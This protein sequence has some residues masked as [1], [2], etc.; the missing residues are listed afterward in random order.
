V[1]T[2]GLVLGAQAAGLEPGPVRLGVMF[3]LPAVLCYTFVERPRRFAL[4]LGALLL[5]GALYPGV[6]GRALYRERDFFGVHRVTV[7]PT[8]SF[9]QLV[10]GNTVH[11]RQSLDPA[12]RRLPLTYYHPSGPIGQVFGALRGDPRLDRVG[13][14]GLGAGSLACYAEAGQHWTYFEIDPAVVRIA[15]D[16]ALFTF[17]DDCPARLDVVLGDAR[18]TLARGDERFGVLVVDAFNSDAI[19]LYLLTREAL[20]VYRA[21][22][23]EDG[24][25]AFNISNRY[26]DLAPVLGDLAAD[27]RP[28]LVCLLQE[29]LSLTDAERAEGKSPSQWVVMASDR[30]HLGKLAHSSR[31]QPLAGRP[32]AAVWTDDY[33]NLLG[34]FKWRERR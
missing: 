24:L 14:I 11:G 32:G 19:P 17:Y 12:R 30:A 26:L 15:R 7:D 13:L 5:A 20:R 29:D 1:L 33:S 10:H 28:P 34:V 8:H 27:A 16:P 21:R 2:A 31:W 18:L 22:L 23:S 9:R 25:L 6:H 3:G 4:G